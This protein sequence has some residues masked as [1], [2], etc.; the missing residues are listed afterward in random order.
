MLL[1]DFKTCGLLVYRDV[2]FCNLKKVTDICVDKSIVYIDSDEYVDYVLSNKD[3]VGVIITNSFLKYFEKTNIGIGISLS[4][5]SSFIK[6]NNLI[7]NDFKTTVIGENCFISDNCVVSPYGVKIGNNVVIEKNVI[8]NSGVI[9][10]DNVRIKT[11]TILGTEGYE[12]C[13]DE[14]DDIVYAIHK[15]VLVIG[16][17]VVISENTCIDKALLSWEQTYIGNNCYICRNV[18][19]CHGTHISDNVVVSNGVYIS[20]HVDIGEKTF[21]GSGVIIPN[22]I[23]IG[24]NVIIRLGSVISKNINDGLDISGNFAIDHNKH[25]EIIKKISK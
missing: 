18:N 23:K 13:F 10:G 3:I 25:I 5:K 6:M 4:P 1:S 7:S 8:I 15:G 20:G 16:N 11:N 12:K 17:N 19:I 21:I 24:K 9:I 14:N 22:R 2:S